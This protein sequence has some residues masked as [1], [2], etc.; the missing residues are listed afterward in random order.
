MIESWNSGTSVGSQN[1]WKGVAS[2]DNKMENHRALCNE[3]N[4]KHTDEISDTHSIVRI[5]GSKLTSTTSRQKYHRP[6]WELY[7]T[8][9]YKQKTRQFW[10]RVQLSAYFHKGFVHF[11]WRENYRCTGC[12]SLNQPWLLRTI[13]RSRAWKQ[14][15]FLHSTSCAPNKEPTWRSVYQS[16]SHHGRENQEYQI[17]IT[18]GFICRNAYGEVDNLLVAWWFWL[19]RFSRRVLP[20]MREEIQIWTN[21]DGMHNNDHV[22]LKKTEAVHQLNFEETS[23]WLRAKDS[24][25]LLAFNQL[26]NA[27]FLFVWRTR[28]TQMQR[29]QSSTTLR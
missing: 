19:Y 20:S 25:H 14:H 15:Y 23:S 22:S 24:P 3:W 13:C 1:A 10:V 8:E 6:R 7:S 17:Y 2:L 29:V 27:V 5:R 26:R 16:D 11:I 9:E 18:Q 28:W 21:I 12:D 4:N